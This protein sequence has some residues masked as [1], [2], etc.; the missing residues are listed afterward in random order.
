MSVLN[1]PFDEYRELDLMNASVLVKGRKSMKELR[2]AKEVGFVAT[3]KMRF[4]SGVHCLLLEPEQFDATYA[5]VPDFHLDRGNLTKDGEQ[6]TSKATKYVKAKVAE[7]K[8]ANKDKEFLPHEDVEKAKRMIEAIRNHPSA[9]MWFEDSKKEVTIL[10]E[11][12]GLRFKGRI[13]LF[14]RAIVDLKNT[15]NASPFAF[16]GIFARLR[17]DMRLAIY[18]ELARQHDG[19]VRDVYII[20]QEDSEP[21]DTVV[22]PIQSPV[23]DN[24]ID[25]VK[26]LVR[27]Y[28]KCVATDE[29]PGIDKGEDYVELHLPQWFYGEDQEDGLDWSDE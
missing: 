2:H 25:Q 29:W 13:D 10:G 28:K 11:I 26:G 6:S 9:N 5:V 27:E 24:A 8:E 20:A 3:D 23:L 1:I 19:K 7:F 15:N 18:R 12:E 22:Y 16:G 21:F 4:G 17:Y 14:G